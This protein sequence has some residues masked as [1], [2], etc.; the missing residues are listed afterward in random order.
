MNSSKCNKWTYF[1]ETRCTF[2]KCLYVLGSNPTFQD[3]IHASLPLYNCSYRW[4][5]AT[6]I[7]RPSLPVL[8]S[9]KSHTSVRA[10]FRVFSSADHRPV[11][12]TAGDRTQVL[13]FSVRRHE[14]RG[15][16][17]DTLPYMPILKRF[18]KRKHITF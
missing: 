15:Y 12:F 4:M 13:W 18:C 3:S 16:T 14:H 1:L 8:S 17:L 9:L 6:F 7:V 10:P 5:M 11:L 2:V